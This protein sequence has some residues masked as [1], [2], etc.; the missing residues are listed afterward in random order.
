[1]VAD[2]FLDHEVEKLL[3]EVGVQLGLLGK[4][5]QAG[6]LGL[7]PGRIRRWQV[8]SRLIN[9][10]SLRTLE[11]FRQQMDQCGIKIIDAVSQSQQF[12]VA[13]GAITIGKAALIR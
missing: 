9:P 2:D 7:L 13:H 1:M 12:R 10:H 6:N 3:G 4:G 5:A 11:A 8:M